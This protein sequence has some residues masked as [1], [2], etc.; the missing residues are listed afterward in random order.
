MKVHDAVV[1]R[2]PFHLLLS[3]SLKNILIALNEH[4]SVGI[5]PKKSNQLLIILTQISIFRSCALE[6]MKDECLEGPNLRGRQN[7]KM[8]I[9]IHL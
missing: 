5:R 9:L 4:R 1:F 2:T 8:D 7:M 3:C 6:I